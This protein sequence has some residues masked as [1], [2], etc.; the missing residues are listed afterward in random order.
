MSK[1][2]IENMT[3]RAKD[4]HKQTKNNYLPLIKSIV[5]NSSLLLYTKTYFI[6]SSQLTIAK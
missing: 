2:I 4:I 6:Q 5:G 3:L 1:Q